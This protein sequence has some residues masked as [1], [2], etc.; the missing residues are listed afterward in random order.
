[1]LTL[2]GR[3][4]DRYGWQARFG[5]IF[6]QATATAIERGHHF[7]FDDPGAYSGAICTWWAQQVAPQGNSANP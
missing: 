3:K 6:P 7:P 4:N 5:Q 2:F 1:V